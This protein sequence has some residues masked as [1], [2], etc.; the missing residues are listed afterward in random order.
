MN[1]QIKIWAKGN[2][3]NIMMMYLS[4]LKLKSYIPNSFIS[5]IDIPIF[6]INIP[7]MNTSGLGLHNK[8]TTNSKQHGYVPVS[9]LSYAASVTNASFVSLEG[10]CQHVDNF[11]KKSEVDYDK[12]F[13]PLNGENGGTENDIVINIRGGDILQ[14]IHPHYCLIPPEFYSFVINKTKKLPIFY[15][16]LDDSPYMRELRNRF[17]TAR[18]IESRGVREDFDFIRK[19]KHII[20]CLSTFSWMASWLSKA[21]SIH[22]PVA[23]VLNPM[24]HDSSMLVPLQDSRYHFYLFPHFYALHVDQYKEYIDPIRQS[25]EPIDKKNLSEIIKN[26]VTNIDD[27]ICS[28]DIDDYLSMYHDQN[29]NFNKFGAVGIFNEYM[30]NGFFEKKYPI[31]LDVPFYTRKYPQVAKDLAHRRYTTAEDHYV[32]IGRYMGLQKKPQ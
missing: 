28:L 23:G 5:N 29:N 16:Q 27:Y 1:L 12:L 30:N 25:W 13:P 14:G 8:Q 15:G 26:D 18:F 31:K 32:F 17:P 21:T 6:N 4:A 24:Q 3:G 20:P 10:F 7:D 11:P 2:P 22:F 19:S 9:G